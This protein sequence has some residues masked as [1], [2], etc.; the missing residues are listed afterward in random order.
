MSFQ[1]RVKVQLSTNMEH[2]VLVIG[3]GDLNHIRKTCPC[4]EYPLNPTFT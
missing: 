2:G 3:L 4:N 1:N